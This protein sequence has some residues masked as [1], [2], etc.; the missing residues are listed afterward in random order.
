MALLNWENKD[1]A[2]ACGVTPQSISNIK[3][4]MT[5]APPRVM[6][7]IARVFDE[8]GI[9]FADNSGVR[10]KPRNI[11][12]Y[13]GTEGFKKFMDDVYAEEQK[14]AAQ[15]GGDKP[16]CVSSFDDRQFNKHLGEYYMVHARRVLA[17]ENVKVRVLVQEGPFHCFPEEKTGAGGFREYRFNP[18]L[19]VGNVPF[20]V[21]GDKL[22]IMIFQED[23]P[24]Q[25]VVIHSTLV[26]KTY[27][28][29]FEV[30]WH[31]ATPCHKKLFAV[32]K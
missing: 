4:G 29:M 21:Y 28:E 14:P 26:T 17:L 7:A 30:L 18:Q 32:K 19:A 5:Q 15:I 10:F 22:A 6:N 16:V 12:V 11:E 1:L 20:Y 8:H 2:K 31:I 25:I 13:K 27:R 3:N 24:P 9:E 23:E